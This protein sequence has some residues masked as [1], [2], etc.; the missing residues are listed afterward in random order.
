M[1]WKFLANNTYLAR[2]MQIKY[3]CQKSWKCKVFSMFL[4]IG[5]ILQRPCNYQINCELLAEKR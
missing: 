5:V 4:Q 1:S 3:S 2:F